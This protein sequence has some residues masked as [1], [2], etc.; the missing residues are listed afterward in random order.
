M[1]TVKPRQ[2][3][4]A[5]TYHV[6]LWAD[7]TALPQDN[8]DPNDE[9][10][11]CPTCGAVEF[12]EFMGV[13]QGVNLNKGGP[14]E[15]PY[16]DETLEAWVESYAHAKRLGRER[17]LEMAES[18][19]T[20]RRESEA[21]RAWRE[22]ADAGAAELDRMDHDPWYREMKDKI[23]VEVNTR[24]GKKTVFRRED[25]QAFARERRPRGE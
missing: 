16:Y 21:R 14:V 7:G 3:P 8:A 15:Y 5:H 11:D 13:G 22:S 2:C 4:N 12:T 23:G 6:L 19:N 18:R 9:S 25:V 17:G 10:L 24:A 1:P 20:Y